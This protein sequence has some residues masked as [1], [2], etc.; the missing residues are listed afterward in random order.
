M[1]GDDPIVFPHDRRPVRFFRNTRCRF[2]LDEPEPEPLPPSMPLLGP[3]SKPVESSA[4]SAIGSLLKRKRRRAPPGGLVSRLCSLGDLVTRRGHNR[5]T[6]TLLGRCRSG[7]GVGLV[8]FRDSS[9][10]VFRRHDGK[11]W[12]ETATDGDPEIAFMPRIFHLPEVLAPRGGIRGEPYRICHEPDDNDG[13]RF[14]FAD[15][16]GAGRSDWRSELKP[17]PHR[18]QAPVLRAGLLAEA[19]IHAAAIPRFPALRKP[20]PGAPHEGIIGET[21]NPDGQ[22]AVEDQC[23]TGQ[24]Y[25]WPDYLNHRRFSGAEAQAVS[26]LAR[27]IASFLFFR[28]RKR[29][30][31]FRLTV[32]AVSRSSENERYLAEVEVTPRRGSGEC[33][34]YPP[35]VTKE[36]EALLVG[37][38]LPLPRE[39]LAVCGVLQPTI[40][41]IHLSAPP[42]EKEGAALEGRFLDYLRQVSIDPDD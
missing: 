5:M 37:P 20:L 6:E 25:V 38:E 17:G 9:V 18:C 39:R 34:P 33:V 32:N 27:D 28:H 16:S 40:A 29:F 10:L 2:V 36:A 30:A 42:G 8:V 21:C 31:T 3:H 22:I 41:D 12:P 24:R 23:L 1:S 7:A 4:A 19:R 15:A 35:D 14:I 11:S 26:G 13:L